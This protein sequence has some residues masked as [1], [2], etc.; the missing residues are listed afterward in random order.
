LAALFIL[1]SGPVVSGQVDYERPVTVAPQPEDIGAGYVVPAVQHTA[2]RS[3]WWSVADVLLLGAALLAAAWIAHL[4]RRRWMA[5]ALAIVCL[6]YFGF[7]RQGCVCPVGSIQNV[8]AALADP[9]LAVPFVVLLIFLLPLLAALLVGRVFCAGVCP[10]GAI[11][12][13]VVLRPLQLPPS[14]DRWGGKLRYLYLLAAV[15]YAAQPAAARDIIICRFDPFVGFFR[16]SGAAEILLFGGGL[17]VLGAFVGRPYCRFLCP[18]GAL[19]SL[20]ARLAFKP[21]WIT[22]D[23]ELDCGL[24]AESCPFGAIRD[25]RADS[26]SCLACARCFASCPRQ[27]YRWGEITLIDVEQLA[28]GSTSRTVT[29]AESTASCPPS[30]E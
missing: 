4:G 24:C 21:V 13:L 19:L 26:A 23:E 28:R 27:R 15:W 25:L 10:L 17:L 5:T 2:P 14:V 1:V 7:Y 9:A 16:L 22:P 18:Y 30:V 8:A 20:V 6:V 3:V 12:E 29:H 11:Q